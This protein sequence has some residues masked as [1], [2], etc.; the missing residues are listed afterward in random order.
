M[1]IQLKQVYLPPLCSDGDRYLV[2]RLWPR[3]LSKS[4]A[5][6]SGW[7]KQLAPSAE[8]RRWYHADRSRWLEFVGQY[9]E[10]LNANISMVD[11]FFDI[12]KERS[13]SLVYA[14]ASTDHRHA[15]IL[16]SHLLS[17]LQRYVAKD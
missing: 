4:K 6:L 3:G 10:E 15:A 12:V 5:Q 17:K 14:T 13:I 8:L 1:I 9:E 7:P 11:T 16:K 2:D